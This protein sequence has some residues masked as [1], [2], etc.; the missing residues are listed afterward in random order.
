MPSIVPGDGPVPCPLMI[1]GERP[2]LTEAARGRA[3]VGHAGKELW[4]RIWKV[5]RMTRDQFYVT[6]LVKTFRVAPPSAE[7]ITRDAPRLHAEL[8]KVQPTVVLTIGYHAARWFLPQFTEVSG[9]HFHGLPFAFQ[10]G[11]LTPRTALVVPVIHAAAALR[12]PD[13]YQNQL[14]ADLRAVGDLLRH[15]GRPH[16]ARVPRPYRVGFAGF[17]KT[18]HTLGL[19]TEG[20]PRSPECVT[21]T[22]H[23]NEVACVEVWGA[24]R[25]PYLKPVVEHARR[26]VFHHA[27]HD[28]QVLQQLGILD[29]LSPHLP[30]V[31][32]TML[33]AYLLGLPQSLKVLA[34]RELGY[35]MR[36]YDDLVGPLDE[37]WVRDTLRRAHDGWQQTHEALG[38]KA[39][40][41]ATRKAT[42]ARVTKKAVAKTYTRL[43]T[44]ADVP[45][46]RTVKGVA[47]M[48]GDV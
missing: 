39:H 3:F 14:S 23:G 25:K 6:N 47:R 43:A 7:E 36:E 42:G 44:H 31:D 17:G 2:G 29:F 45:R 13:R 9:D 27:T 19:D 11:R 10:Y 35:Q 26:V 18:G 40:R 4:S 32:D 20:S 30:R 1:V 5:L 33:M 12:Q 22:H 21:V 15:G 24:V 38:T 8:L 34:Y 46:M 37:A 16:V 28:W 41:I 48:I